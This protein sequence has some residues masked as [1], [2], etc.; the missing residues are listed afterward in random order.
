MDFLQLEGGK[1]VPLFLEVLVLLR[2]GN[3]G[4]VDACPLQNYSERGVL[5]VG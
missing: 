2:F 3:V 4:D 1:V 5:H